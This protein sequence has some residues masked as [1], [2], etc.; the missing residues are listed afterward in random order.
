MSTAE[1]VTIHRTDADGS[2]SSEYS[3]T[4]NGTIYGSTPGGTR[5]IYDR[6]TLLALANSQ[7]AKTPPNRM[8]HV[9]GI[10]KSNPQEKSTPSATSAF[11]GASPY[12]KVL[13]RKKE[14][15]EKKKTYNPFA[16]LN[17]EEDDVFD[18]DE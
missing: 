10:T 2:L 3:T 15:Q 13:E 14:E 12:R 5:V 18:M 9:P 7:L 6:T 4:P 17:E 1:P 8:A 11:V 16:L